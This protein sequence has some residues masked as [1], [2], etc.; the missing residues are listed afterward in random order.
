V[1]TR[2][3]MTLV[4]DGVEN[5]WNAR[6]MRDAATMFDAACLFRDRARLADTW[7]AA[8]PDAAPLDTIGAGDLAREYAPLALCDNLEGA[9]DIYGFNLGEGTRP[10][11]I[12]GNERRGIAR[13]LQDL[14]HRR[15]RIPMV[16]RRITCLNVAA[17]AA[18]ALYYLSRG[19]GATQQQSAHPHKRRPDLLMV[20]ATD[21][22][23]LGSAIRSAAAFGWERVLVEDRA[24]AW[25]GVDRATRSEG[26]AAA[27]R[28]RNAIRV[29][30]ATEEAR[31]AYDEVCVVTTRQKGVPLHRANLAKGARQLLAIPDE[32][33]VDLWAET[34]A[35][36]GKKVTVARIDAPAEQFPYHYR[37][38]ATIAL[39]EA[40]RQIGR[41]APG[42]DRSGRRGPSYDSALDLLDQERGE[43]VDLADLALY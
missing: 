30:P 36:S 16:S 8:M 21:H 27:R 24:G 34:W 3:R 6:T 15:V 4:G 31:H 17:A 38:V 1:V 39:A 37:L 18:V 2:P 9:A 33:A 25:F 10:A 40:A 20:G 41:P 7:V 5:P 12:V 32:D 14:P 29:I 11:V 43:E 26:R 35:R 42:T 23:E 19:G 22:V 13:D 28:G